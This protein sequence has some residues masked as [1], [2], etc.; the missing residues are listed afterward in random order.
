MLEE[1]RLLFGPEVLSPVPHVSSPLRV[2][3]AGIFLIEGFR[4]RNKGHECVTL[5]REEFRRLLG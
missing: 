5:Q 3:A 1:M 2:T 4:D